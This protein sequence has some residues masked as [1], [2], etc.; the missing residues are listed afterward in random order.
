M[1]YDLFSLSLFLAVAS[2]GSIAKAAE[3]Q[4]IAASAVSRRISE[5]EDLVGTP[6]FYRRQRGVELTPA[7]HELRRYARSITAEVGRMDAALSDYSHGK[8]GTVRIAANTSAITQF[9]PEDLAEF[10]ENHPDVRIKLVE[11]VSTD[12]LSMVR[13]GHADFGIISGLTPQEDL[14]QITYRKDQLVVAAPKGHRILHK[15]EVSFR[16][17]LK[18][19]MVSLQTGSS[20]QAFLTTKAE[21]QGMSIQT[22]VEVMSFDGVRRMVQAGLGVAVLPLGAVQPYLQ[23][24]EIG[25]VPVREDWAERSLEIVYRETSSFAKLPRTLVEF[26]ISDRLDQ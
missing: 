3:L 13:T 1:H 16:D 19:D 25:M 21:E 8:K 9:L 20:I 2:L 26:L 10:Q 11:L 15:S 17:I 14:K 12:I 22:R 4:N 7:G 5:L 23:A 24:S 6:L 18:E